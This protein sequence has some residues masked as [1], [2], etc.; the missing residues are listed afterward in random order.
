MLSLALALSTAS[1][2]FGSEIV[3]LDKPCGISKESHTR[4]FDRTQNG[5]AL[6]LYFRANRLLRT[7][8]PPYCAIGTRYRPHR[9][10]AICKSA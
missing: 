7:G 5:G 9:L 2:R 6:Y 1:S 4:K 3:E 8:T 10:T